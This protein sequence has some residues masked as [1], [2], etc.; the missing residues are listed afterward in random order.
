MTP[1]AAYVIGT[2][3]EK[4]I[5]DATLTFTYAVSSDTYNDISNA[6]V[7]THVAVATGAAAPAVTANSIRLEKVVTSGT[8]ITSVVRLVS[9]RSLPVAVKDPVTGITVLMAGSVAIPTGGTQ[10]VTSITNNTDGTV[11]TYVKNGVTYTVS[12]NAAGYV[13]VITGSDGSTVTPT[14]DVNNAV[15]AVTVA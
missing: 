15:T 11:N 3:V 14:Y 10:T 8:A 7:I 9:G 5:A 1:G 13:S 6:G 2:R 12:Y 4:L